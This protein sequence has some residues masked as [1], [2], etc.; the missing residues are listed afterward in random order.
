MTKRYN[1]IDIALGLI[2][3]PL[4]W[5]AGGLLLYNFSDAVSDSAGLVMPRILT[6]VIGIFSAIGTSLVIVGVPLGMILL[7]VGVI[8]ASRGYDQQRVR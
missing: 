6:V 2:V 8:R 7:V 4:V 3:L 1:L 5:L